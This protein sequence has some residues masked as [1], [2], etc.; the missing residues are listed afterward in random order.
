M[1]FL[2]GLLEGEKG[3]TVLAVLR[4]SRCGGLF[5]LLAASLKISELDNYFLPL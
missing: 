4:F 1:A 5:P 3:R 2:G